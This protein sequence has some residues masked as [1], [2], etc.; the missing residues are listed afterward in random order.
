MTTLAHDRSLHAILAANIA[1]IAAALLFGWGLGQLLWPYWIQSVIIGFYARRRMLMLQDFCTEGFK[2]NNRPVA[3]TPETR[4]QTANFFAL[5]YGVFHLFYLFFLSAFAAGSDAS[6]NLAVTNTSTG[7][8]SM[9]HIGQTDGLDLLI[10]LAL[11]IGF[12]LSHR[13]SHREHVQADLAR[14]PNIGSLMFLPYLRIIPM[15]LTIIFG[16]V[17]GGGLALVFF[18]ALKTA[19]DIAMHRVEH[20]WLQAGKAL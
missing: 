19:A 6:G 9:L 4:K 3:P 10:Y 14:K 16:A 5:H 11:G 20:R 15:H 2:V 13:A 17:L 8:V 18:A 12:W 7:E 1:T